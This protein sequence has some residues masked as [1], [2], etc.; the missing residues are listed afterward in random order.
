MWQYRPMSMLGRRRSPNGS[1]RSSTMN[2][3]SKRASRKHCWRKIMNVH[4]E[5]AYRLDPVL[6]A[7]HV[8]GIAPHAWQEKFLR[9]ELGASIAVLTARQVG[10]TTAAAVG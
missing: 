2:Q 7:R 9:A 3:N 5:V 8:L 6:G 10:K 4:R 1:F